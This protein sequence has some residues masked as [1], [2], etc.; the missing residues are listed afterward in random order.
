LVPQGRHSLKGGFNIL[1]KFTG[2]AI[3]ALI[4]CTAF[5]QS[6]SGLKFEA[7]D[8]HATPAVAP[9]SSNNQGMR[10]GFYRGGRYEVRNATMVDLI[11][12]AYGVTDSDKV[13]GGPAWLDKDHFDVIAKAPAD[14]T[15]E[16]LQAMLRDLLADRF[17]LVVHNDTKP[18]AAYVITQGKK[19]LMK[20]AGGS[21]A[22][23]C[24]LIPPPQPPPGGPMIG[25]SN[26]TVQVTTSPGALLTYTCH[27][28]SM[29]EMPA[30]LRNMLFALATLNVTRVVDQTELKGEWDFDIKYTL[31][32]GRPGAPAAEGAPEVVTIFT[33]LDKQLGLKLELSKIP[34]AVVAVDSVNETPTDNLPGISAKMPTVPTEFEVADIK[35]SD[36]NPPPGPF[37]GG[38]FF[39][40]GGRVNITRYSMSNLIGLAWNLNGN[41]D[42]RIVGL[43]KAAENVNWDIIAKASTMAPLNA[44]PNGQ[45]PQQQVDFDSMRVMLQALLKDRFKLAIHEETRQLPGYVL[46]AVK[47]KLKPADPTDRPG[48][49]EGPGAD[50]KD[51]RTVNSA[52]GRL[53]S[54]LNMTLAEFAAELPNRAGGYFGQVPGG[55]VDATKIEGK[56]DITLNFSAAGMVSGGGGRSGG[57]AGEAVDPGGAISL[58]EAIEKQLGLKLEPQKNPGMVL[59]VDDVE[60]KPTDN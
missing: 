59:V 42:N 50:G 56:Y 23:G 24:K 54:C 11:R 33:A 19:V 39:C 60:E 5:G 27:N 3:A 57:T 45:A 21:D 44:P 6:D 55:V 25:I 32:I 13:T 37:R 41:Y 20:A 52:A 36:P 8:I 2:L 9:G 48:C 46:V 49:K 14:S 53:F 51:P 15:Q 35:P 16:K 18:L 34:M 4:A 30:Q 26:G 31:N 29:P 1:L 22:A 12:T 47:P 17:S 58:Q 40:P 10:G 43:P 28:V 38:C 7:A